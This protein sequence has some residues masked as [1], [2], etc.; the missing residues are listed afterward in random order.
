[1]GPV[2]R[3]EPAQDS[4]RDW[5][6]RV[7]H[8]VYEAALPLEVPDLVVAYRF[9]HEMVPDRQERYFA[10]QRIRSSGLTFPGVLKATVIRP[11]GTSIQRQAISLRKAHPADS[12]VEVVS[13]LSVTR[14]TVDTDRCQA[15]LSQVNRLSG[16]QVSVPRGDMFMVDSPVHQ[17]RLNIGSLEMA[18][19]LAGEGTP[20]VQWADRTHQLLLGC[21]P[22]R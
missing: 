1:M 18:A 19:T 22:A 8:E 12:V 17:F 11:R 3:Q 15:I 16:V 2:N 4:P 7:Q 13:R 21:L 6:L 9:S 20:L 5:F 10:I 14:E